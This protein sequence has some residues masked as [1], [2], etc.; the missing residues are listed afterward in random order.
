MF[1]EQC[2]MDRDKYVYTFFLFN[3]T[4]HYGGR[5]R[6]CQPVELGIGKDK[7]KLNL[8]EWRRF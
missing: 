4:V 1:K 2:Q 7:A 6:F 8:Q 5:K 3:I